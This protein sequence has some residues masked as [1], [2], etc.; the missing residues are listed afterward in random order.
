MDVPDVALRVFS[1]LDSRTLGRA[2]C[3]CRDWQ[4]LLEDNVNLLWA[5]HAL[6][7]SPLPGTFPHRLSCETWKD[8]VRVNH[9]WNFVL[10]RLTAETLAPEKPKQ[11]SALAPIVT[12][13]IEVKQDASV[14]IM[15]SYS[16]T[17]TRDYIQTQAVGSSVIYAVTGLSHVN[18]LDIKQDSIT[19]P[20]RHLLADTTPRQPRLHRVVRSKVVPVH[21]G[22][23]VVS[24]CSP[25]DATHRVRFR[26]I[27]D[28]YCQGQMCGDMYACFNPRW[29]DD[30]H[31]VIDARKQVR[32]WDLSLPSPAIRWNATLPYHVVDVAL[33]DCIVAC[34]YGALLEGDDAEDRPDLA[35]KFGI[36]LRSIFTGEFISTIPEMSGVHDVIFLIMTRF[37]LLVVRMP[38]GGQKITVVSLRTSKIVCEID[39]MQS[40]IMTYGGCHVNDDET[41][42]MLWSSLDQLACIDLILG[43]C[44][45]FECD[46]SEASS[47][48]WPYGIWVALQSKNKKLRS[49]KRAQ[50]MWKAIGGVP[51][52]KRES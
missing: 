44:A 3:V 40:F 30:P 8:L 33:N 12:A 42:L 27:N 4:R 35:D 38:E 23:G 16:A 10:P 49:R 18:V 34:A 25:S 21:E 9:C 48:N 24:F 2:E 52:S 7:S 37:H 46:R 1:F 20:S 14:I 43:E 50:V 19:Q 5:H 31:E 15:D 17:D 45:I 32:L 11:F 41:I 36:E 51:T 28:E 29:S 39:L 47:V 13:G 6:D 26:A 22:A